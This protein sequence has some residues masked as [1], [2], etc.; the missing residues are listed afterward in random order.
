MEK[1]SLPVLIA[2]VVGVG[3]LIACGELSLNNLKANYHF[4]KANKF[5]TDQAFRKAVHEYELAVKYNP[6]FPKAYLFLGL[7][8]QTLYKPGIDTPENKRLAEKA[9]EN[10]MKAREFEPDNEDIILS[11]G[12][13]YN[14][15]RNFEEA[16][17]YYLEILG[18]HPNEP[19]YYY[20]VAQFYKGF[21]KYDKALEMFE[22]RISL[23]PNNPEGYK[24]LANFYQNDLLGVAQDQ[25]T[26]KNYINKAIELLEKIISL[27]PNNYE[28]YYSL[29]VACW[30][31]S[32]R[33]IPNDFGPERVEAI[34]KGIKALEKAIELE[35]DF[36]ESYAWI[37]LLWREMAKVD[38][39][40]EGR[41]KQIATD[42]QNKFT[43]IQNRKKAREALIK[44]LQKQ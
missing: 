20:V 36:A 2:L 17:K 15:L 37:N 32:Y 41:Y 28:G 30:A 12:E 38:P 34:N 14:R 21:E 39:K 6:N 44:A 7:S 18:R 9:I 33:V 40:N 42:Y 1:R 27:E 26:G 16:E 35:P 3:L 13:T 43:E 25:E 19:K 8:Y 23:D 29:G 22:K 31:K 10:L 4:K 24:Y 11:L 5:Y